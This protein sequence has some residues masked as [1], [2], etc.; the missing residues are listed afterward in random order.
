MSFRNSG[1]Q[2]EE[3]ESYKRYSAEMRRYPLLTPQEEQDLARRSRQGDAKARDRLISC[4]LRFVA[5]VA[6]KYQNQGLSLLELICEGNKG[7]ITAA[8]KFDETKGF[9]FISYAVWWIKRAIVQAFAD[10][11]RTVRIPVNVSNEIRK[12]SSFIYQSISERACVPEPD[13][14]IN[15]LQLTTS[16]LRNVLLAIKARFAASFDKQFGEGDDGSDN[17]NLYDLIAD[18]TEDAPDNSIDIE[19]L[20]Q[21]VARSTGRLSPREAEILNL[22]FGLD[23][24]DPITLEEIGVIFGLTRERIRQIKVKA[25]AKL[26]AGKH[27]RELFQYHGGVDALNHDE[28]EGRAETIISPVDLMRQIIKILYPSDQIDLEELAELSED[29]YGPEAELDELTQARIAV[30]EQSQA[31]IKVSGLLDPAVYDYSETLMAWT[32]LVSSLACFP[33]LGIQAQASLF[34]A[35]FDEGGGNIGQILRTQGIA[36]A[37]VG[38][39]RKL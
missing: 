35:L 18:E 16:Q 34:I 2:Y 14:V 31:E 15:A 3:Y 23:G 37:F 33:R 19:S 26:R 10:N 20:K 24:Q 5:S 4:N 36:G 29:E 39:T 22:Y 28:T 13:E 17:R 30:F 11:S 27:K 38:R 21:L 25:L 32:R 8:E 1:L 6:R 12:I 7:L 9:K